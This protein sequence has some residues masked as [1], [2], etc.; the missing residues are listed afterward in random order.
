MWQPSSSGCARWCRLMRRN[1]TGSGRPNVIA[2]L[3]DPTPEREWSAL[4]HEA[5]RILAAA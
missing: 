5:G 2:G 4:Y 3:A 1:T